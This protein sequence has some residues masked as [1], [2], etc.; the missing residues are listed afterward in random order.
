MA[1]SRLSHIGICV[2]DLARSQRF[3]C[4]ALG[5]E[6]LSSLEI[7]GPD[8]GGGVG[9]TISSLGLGTFSFTSSIS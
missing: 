7:S 5:F 2:S 8:I 9:L 1:E 6:V 4:E 3:Y